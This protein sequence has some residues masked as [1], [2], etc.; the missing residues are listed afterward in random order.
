M[1]YNDCHNLTNLI[2]H[3]ENSQIEKLGE[4]SQELL[5][6]GYERKAAMIMRVAEKMQHLASSQKKG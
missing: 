2:W 3:A 6:T 1:K 4:W 5:Q